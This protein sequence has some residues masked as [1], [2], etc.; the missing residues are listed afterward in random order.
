MNERE[1]ERNE[2][3]RDTHTRTHTYMRIDGTGTKIRKTNEKLK[4]K[5]DDQ[6][7]GK[8]DK[9]TAEAT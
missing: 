4:Q 5:T 1:R 2:R 8:T 6:H 3:G 7:T 9:N